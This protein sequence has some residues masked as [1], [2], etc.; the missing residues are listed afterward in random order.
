MFVIVLNSKVCLVVDRCWKHLKINYYLMTTKRL[1]YLVFN[2]TM[3]E[4]CLFRKD[5]KW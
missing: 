2:V 3:E 4:K 1:L 5:K